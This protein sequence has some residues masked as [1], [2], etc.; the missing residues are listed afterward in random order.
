M[1]ALSTNDFVLTLS[2]ISLIMGVL[3]F[4][5]GIAILA[6]KVRSEEFNN[7]SA[8]TAKLMDKGIVEDMNGLVQNT[9][10]LLQAI[11]QM[12]RTKAGIG[13][14]LVLVAFVLIGVSY[15]LITRVP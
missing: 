14:F 6:F 3:T 11:N 7:I 13:M 5:I 10:T 15:I 2:G 1:F 8:H 12:A 4:I 9:S